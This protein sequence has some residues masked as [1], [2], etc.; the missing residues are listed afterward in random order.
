MYIFI[1]LMFEHPNNHGYFDQNWNAGFAVFMGIVH[2]IDS[3][4]KKSV[5]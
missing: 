5:A 4:N 3:I 2:S 1:V